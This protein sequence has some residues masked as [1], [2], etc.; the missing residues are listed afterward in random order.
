MRLTLAVALMCVLAGPGAVAAAQGGEDAIVGIWLTQTGD[1]FVKIERDGERYRGRIVGAP[2]GTRDDQDTRD[3]NNPDPALR[4]RKVQGLLIMGDYS[5]NGKRWVNGW[6]YDPDVGKQYKSNI[7]L[8]GPDRLQMRGYI[9]TPLLGRSQVWTR[10]SEDTP[11][12][13][14]P[15]Q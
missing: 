12:V 10:V 15:S 2:P 9:G 14:L 3:V 1:G 6:V 4:Q 11:G 13:Q 8:K 7:K 5:F